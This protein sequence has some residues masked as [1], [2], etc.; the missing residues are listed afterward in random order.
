M[1]ISPNTV[2]PTNK[3]GFEALKVPCRKCW[4][5][6]HDKINDLIGRC[7]C[8]AH[9]SDHVWHVTLTYDDKKITDPQQTRI[10]QKSDF[11]DFCKRMRRN[12]KMRYLVVSETGKNNSK[13]VHF[14]AILFF[15]GTPPQWEHNK[16]HWDLPKWPWGHIWV[17][18][19]VSE[20]SMRYVVKY[21]L[22]DVQNEGNW[23]SYSRIP[24]M[25]VDHATWYGQRYATEKLIPRNFK[26]R[27]PGAHDGRTYQFKGES[28]FVML[29][30]LFEQWPD[31]WQ[32]PMN[33]ALRSVV[34]AYVLNRQRKTFEAMC[35]TAQQ[36]EYKKSETSGFAQPLTDYSKM[37]YLWESYLTHLEINFG[38]EARAQA[39]KDYP[40]RKG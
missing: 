14:H 31:A 35:A 21:A 1:C 38:K 16:R 29:D 30:A 33:D 19:V 27:P 6:V 39:E 20:T 7:L 4:A 26:Y 37:A 8:E 5:C 25:G 40:G 24:I 3:P 32:K 13:R 9:V 15:K 22:K 36:L 17:D 12:F 18:P 11:Q 10:P 34:K 2:Y 23:L 28:R